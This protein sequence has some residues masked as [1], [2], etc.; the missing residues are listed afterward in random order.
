MAALIEL[1]AENFK[2]LQAVELKLDKSGNVIIAGRNAQGKSSVLDAIV[3]A[4]CGKSHIDQVPVRVGED[5]ATISCTVST[6]PPL[7][8]VRR[9]KPDG[10]TTLTI[11]Q[12]VGEIES[13]VSRPQQTLDALVGKVAFDPL[14]FTRLRPSE[15]MTLLKELVG[16]STDG[17]DWEIEQ[18][19]EKRKLTNRDVEQL[20]GQLAGMHEYEE[21]EP[22]DVSAVMAEL[23]KANEHNESISDATDEFERKTESMYRLDEEA[24]EWSE[25]IKELE[26]KLRQ[27]REQLEAK[28]KERADMKNQLDARAIE[29]NTMQPI[30]TSPLRERINQASEINQR[31]QANR[32]REQVAAR[33]KNTKAESDTLT[34]S[35][36]D[37]RQRRLGLMDSA[38]WPVEGL[39]FGPDGVTFQGLPFSQ[40]SSAEQLKISTAI[41]LSQNPTLRLMMIRDGSLLDDN[42]LAALHA[43]AVEHNAQIIV[44]RVGTGKPGEIVIE[45]GSVLADDDCDDDRLPGMGF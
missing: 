38:K 22:V 14:A 23:D 21:A 42:S 9:I 26:E 19:L 10:N 39:G 35:I 45:D 4:L 11:T 41:G 5:E 44:E 40:C 17:I 29:I 36:E 30:D 2:R 13:K 7:R 1:R 34:K 32:D 20:K 15:Q 28:L 25:H 33:L 6:E 16:V 31:V 12:M 37:L 24:E 27:S 18:A 8:I 43:L 3:A